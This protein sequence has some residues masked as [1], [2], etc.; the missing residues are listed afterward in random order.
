MYLFFLF[1]I[2]LILTTGITD[3]IIHGTANG[4]QT[5]IVKM[6]LQRQGVNGHWDQN[7]IIQKIIV[8]YAARE[9]LQTRV[10][11]LSLFRDFASSFYILEVI[12]IKQKTYTSH[13]SSKVF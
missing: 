10:F 4:M 6:E 11:F 1:K 2:A 9:T 3:L 12:S 8:V 7:T 5:Y 13:L